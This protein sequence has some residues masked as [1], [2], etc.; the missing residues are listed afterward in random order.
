MKLN[1]SFKAIE[2]RIIPWKNLGWVLTTLIALFGGCPGYNEWKAKPE[3]IFVREFTMHSSWSQIL[4]RP[5]AGTSILV[6]GAVY[7]KGKAPFF[8]S[9][10]ELHLYIEDK[11]LIIKAS[12]IDK[13]FPKMIQDERV[14]EMGDIH[15]KDFKKL[16][17]VNP[18]DANYGAL[19]FLIEEPA[20]FFEQYPDLKFKI[21][22]YDLARDEYVSE[23]FNFH[24]STSTTISSPKL[25]IYVYDTVP[26]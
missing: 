15:L 2:W 21:V 9:L 26:H 16:T 25:D 12:T 23:A 5:M 11:P 20:T 3:F 4:P 13:D 10:W 6:T 7:N 14:I 8:P 19:L 17:R 1:Y 18:L 24:G 22:C